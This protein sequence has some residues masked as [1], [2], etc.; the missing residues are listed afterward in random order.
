MTIIFLYGAFS[1]SYAHSPTQYK[2]LRRRVEASLTQNGTATGLANIHSEKIFIASTLY[3]R[4]GSLLSGRWGEDLLQLIEFVGP[5]HVHLS[6]YENDPD[7]LAEL[8][9]RDF[10]KRVACEST[11][12]SERLDMKQIPHVRN[13]T[14]ASNPDR[15]AFLAEVRNRALQPL[16]AKT[17]IRYDKVL[18][19]NDVYFDPIDAANLLF[20][21]NVQEDTRRTDY[22]A[23]CAVDF[24]NPLVF[25]DTFAT[26]DAEG[27][28]MGAAIYP[29]FSSAGDGRSRH[30]VLSRSETVRVTSCWSGMVAIE[31]KWFQN[32]KETRTF[33]TAKNDSLSFRYE[34]E[35]FWD[36]SECC[37]IH[38]DLAALS[39]GLSMSDDTGIYLNP[40]VRVAY[41][42]DVLAWLSY[43]KYFERLLLPFQ[44]IATSAASLPRFN[45]RRREQAGEQVTNEVW[46]WDGELSLSAASGSYKSVT[47]LASPGGHCGRRK[48]SII[49][50][51]PGGF[52]KGW[53]SYNAPVQT[54][55]D[56]Q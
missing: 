44:M 54:N 22:R 6:I 25:Y 5:Q 29:W 55:E 50:Q 11:L 23:V 15:I 37:L 27:F 26:R 17:A 3:D 34:T 42:R 18:Y 35:D 9:L 32:E 13:Q 7:P 4:G 47:R 24:K 20:S 36:A 51:R 49:V 46:I 45:P 41:S 19:L 2:S 33:D 14:G 16:K 39:S 1:P 48:Q 8:A 31:A 30:D 21:T 56:D 10:A 12:I 40:F 28:E 43:V 53:A 38:A 52:G